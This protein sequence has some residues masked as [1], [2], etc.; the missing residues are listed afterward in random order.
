MQCEHYPK[1]DNNQ[2]GGC[3][4]NVNKCVKSDHN[5]FLCEKHYSVLDHMVEIGE[6]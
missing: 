4:G 5:H 2:Y 3:Y 1:H 6:K